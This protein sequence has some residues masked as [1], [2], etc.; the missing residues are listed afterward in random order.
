MFNR[1]PE[2]PEA[3]G[4]TKWKVWPVFT[5][6]YL[7]CQESLAVQH[8]SRYNTYRDMCCIAIQHVSRYVCHDTILIPIYPKKVPENIHYDF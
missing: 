3:A 7:M 1:D 5:A 6:N 4:V 2:D 8:V